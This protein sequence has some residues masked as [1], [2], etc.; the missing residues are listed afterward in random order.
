[1]TDMADEPS[2]DEILASLDELLRETGPEEGGGGRALIRES[3]DV[4]PPPFLERKSGTA[5]REQE[6]PEEP[7]SVS[8]T[9]AG[10]PEVPEAAEDVLPEKE[11]A[12]APEAETDRDAGEPH[13]EH[14]EE[15]PRPRL[16][17]TPPEPPVEIRLTPEHLA[18]EERIDRDSRGDQGTG[19]VAR[20]GEA[21]NAAAV[22]PE[23]VEAVAGRVSRRLD[24]ELRRM[25]PA[26]IEGIV[27]ETLAEMRTDNTTQDA[28]HDG[29]DTRENL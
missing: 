17:L 13:P 21:Q 27:R 14:E 22:P 11:L 28:E 4:P 18:P 16:E 24:A 7:E 8:E 9:S 2:I 19:L 12:E 6:A 10:Q 5:L 29:P 23:W 20:A 1:M 26:M 15:D 3:R 25:L